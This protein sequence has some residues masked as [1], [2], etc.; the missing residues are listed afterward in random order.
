[1]AATLAYNVVRFGDPLQFGYGD[2]GFTTPFWNG[3]VG[4]LFH[5]TKSLLLFAPIS[6]VLP[7]ALWHLWRLR[8]WAFLLI[9]GNFVVTFATAAMWFAW[10]GGW[11]WGPRLLIPGL[12]PA[13]AAVG[14][15][16]DRPSRQRIVALLLLS[17][18]IVSFPAL[19]VSTQ[20]QQRELPPISQAELWRGH[21]MPTQPLRSPSP[22][23]Q[24]QLVIPTARYSYEHAYDR[25]TDGRNYLRYFSL[26]QL[27][28]TR[29]L[30]RAGLI[31]GLAATALLLLGVVVA[32]RR[33]TSAAAAIVK[34]ESAE[35]E[36]ERPCGTRLI[37]ASRLAPDG[38]DRVTLQFQH[39]QLTLEIV[40][41]GE[42]N[43]TAAKSAADPARWPAGSVRKLRRSEK[44]VAAGA[45][46]ASADSSSVPKVSGL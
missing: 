16:L 43:K 13:I 11:S 8:P 19:I 22:L 21:Y 12:I 32:W 6:F 31:A 5:P 42:R 18:F 44:S 20:T 45:P 41:P 17:G 36:I 37:N 27:G 14:P 26:W 9:A 46:P 7:F 3:T 29:V 10:H 34:V 40:N 33:V 23:R 15:W 4:L 38:S 1:M 24:A 35:A 25:Q 39:R 30:G 28:A 2:V